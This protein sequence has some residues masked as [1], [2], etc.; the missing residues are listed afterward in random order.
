MRACRGPPNARLS[1]AP[2]RPEI[3]RFIQP[4][5]QAA[6]QAAAVLAA[7]AIALAAPVTFAVWAPAARAEEASVGV[8]DQR[9]DADQAAPA[10][11]AADGP[12]S[13][14]QAAADPAPAGTLGAERVSRVADAVQ[15]DFVEVSRVL[16]APIRDGWLCAAPPVRARCSLR[17]PR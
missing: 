16:C 5:R 15:R 8:L 14:V 10:V 6:Q 13:E 7:G 1:G 17:L 9:R 4:A 12:S 11:L 2:G 3:V